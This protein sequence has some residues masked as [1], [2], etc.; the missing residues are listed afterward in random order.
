MEGRFTLLN[1]ASRQ[2]RRSK[3]F[4]RVKNK[5]NFL[6]FA[7]MPAVFLVGFFFFSISIAADTDLIITEIMFDPDGSDSGREWIE[8]YNPTESD[9]KIKSG[10]CTTS[11]WRFIDQFKE[12]MPDSSHRHSFSEDA[13]IK[14][15]EFLIVA[16]DKNLFLENH[17]E[18]A[19]PVAKSSFSLPN[20][21][22]TLAL[23]NDGGK[24]YFAKTEYEKSWGAS[25]NGKTLEKIDFSKRNEK[26]NWQESFELGGTP[27]EESSQEKIYPREIS[28][29]ELLPIRLSLRS[30]LNLLSYI[31]SATRISILKIGLSRI[32]AG[33]VSA[34]RKMQL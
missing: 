17:P 3:L 34:F 9:I 32:K 31:I 10:T 14:P 8:L 5:N 24:S 26:T 27:G 19:G 11:C 25:G 33:A 21:S 1:A 28:V 15:K 30:R 23:S 13:T 7:I 12:G 29:S 18:Y 4:N 20:E 22:S 2:F 6:L 16:N